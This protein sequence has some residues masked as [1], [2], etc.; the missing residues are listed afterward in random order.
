MFNNSYQVDVFEVGYKFVQEDGS[1]DSR[2]FTSN[3]SYYQCH[4]RADAYLK[5]LQADG[6][7][8]KYT[9]IFHTAHSS[10]MDYDI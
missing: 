3:D 6:K 5:K 9:E 10:H 1:Y 8:I 4:D 2:V 7:K